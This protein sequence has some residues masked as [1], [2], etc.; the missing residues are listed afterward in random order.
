MATRG[1]IDMFLA[2]YDPSGNVLWVN[3]GGG[4]SYDEGASVAVDSSGNTYVTGSFFGTASFG[5]TN[6]TSSYDSDIF[7]V[8]YDNF[9]NL[10]W[11]TQAGVYQDRGYGIAVDGLGNAYVT[12]Y[13]DG[14]TS[15]NLNDTRAADGDVFIHKYGTTGNRIWARQAGGP[16]HD[17]GYG[18]GVDGG[19]NVFVAGQF[20]DFAKFGS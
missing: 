18:I 5:T 12:G 11:A 15:G 2:K 1:I 3:Q 16:R 13:I 8:K 9:G 7:V 6:L 20:N 17:D 4:S 19:G 14:S 10:A